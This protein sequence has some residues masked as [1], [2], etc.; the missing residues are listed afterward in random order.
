MAWDQCRKI[1]V[2][3]GGISSP[4]HI[5]RVVPTRAKYPHIGFVQIAHPFH[6][7]HDIGV[8]AKVDRVAVACDH[9]SGFGSGIGRAAAVKVDAGRMAGIHHGDLNAAKVDRAT[10]AKTDRFYTFGLTPIVGQFVDAQKQK[11]RKNL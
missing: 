7:G 6:V 3:F 10:F 5:H 9:I 11:G 1:E 4:R 8:T 2:A